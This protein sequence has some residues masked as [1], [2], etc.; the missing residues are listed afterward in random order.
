MGKNWRRYGK[1]TNKGEVGT[2][3][4]ISDCQPE[5]PGFNPWHGRGLN[6]GRPSFT[7]PSVDRVVKPL[8]QSLDVLSGDLKEPTH[9]SIRVG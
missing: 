3:G 6:F 1:G 4:K 5:G 9:L 7:T 2:V 8:V